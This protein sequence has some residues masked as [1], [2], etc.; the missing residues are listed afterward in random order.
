[1]TYKTKGTSN[2]F[3]CTIHKIHPITL[4]YQSHFAS[5]SVHLGNITETVYLHF[6][7]FDLELILILF[8][9]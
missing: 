2:I 7:C 6:S 4:C 9:F 1:M 3:V 8:F 5:T